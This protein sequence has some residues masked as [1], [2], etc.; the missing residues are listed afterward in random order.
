VG[1]ATVRV[2]V[3][4]PLAERFTGS[5]CQTRVPVRLGARVDA[6]PGVALGSL[7]LQN[8]MRGLPS[9]NH[10]TPRGFAPPLN[11]SMVAWPTARPRL[12]GPPAFRTFLR[13]SQG[14]WVGQA[15]TN[16]SA[17]P[18]APGG[19]PRRT[20]API[21]VSRTLVAPCGRD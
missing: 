18:G 15:D 12:C 5:T 14:G 4:H 3:G 13:S 16:R 20:G 21:K 19:G 6:T 8:L 1:P 7:V 17:A 10:G 11:E 9:P 2:D